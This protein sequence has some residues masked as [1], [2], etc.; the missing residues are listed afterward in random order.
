MILLS[1]TW[2]LLKCVNVVPCDEMTPSP[3]PF[4][5][6]GSALLNTL[7]YRVTKRN[8]DYEVG[9]RLGPSLLLQCDWSIF[10]FPIC[11]DR[12]IKSKAHIQSVFIFIL[13]TALKCCVTIS[14]AG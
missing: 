13:S 10:F 1:M 3:S 14:L 8:F 6:F 4:W 11:F 12:G 7:S 2:R 5:L 9:S